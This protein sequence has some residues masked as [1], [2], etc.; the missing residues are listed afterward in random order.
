M[1]S[2]LPS[3]DPMPPD[4]SLPPEAVEGI[5]GSP[6]SMYVHIPF[7]RTRCGYCDFNTYTASELPGMSSGDYVSAAHREIALAASVLGDGAPP[8]DTVFFGGGTP[9]MLPAE[10]LAGMLDAIRDRFGLADDA[11]VTTEANPDTVD[12]AYFDRLRESG[13]TRISLGM[14]SVVPHVLSVLERVH[15]PERGLQ[16]ARWAAEAGFDHVSLDLIYGTPGESADDWMASLEAVAATPVDHVSAY[17]LIVEEG[18]RLAMQVRRG[19]IPMPDDDELAD[20]Y[21]MA[22]QF[23]TGHGFANY[24]VSNWAATPSGQ[25]RHNLN[26]W[27][28]ANWW[29]VGPGAHSH[30]GGLRFWNRKHPRSYVAELDAG[31]SPV[32][33]GEQLSAEDRRI[34]TVMLELRLAEGL[35]LAVLTDSERARVPETV[36]RGLGVIEGQRLI[37]TLQG[38]LLADG[39][40]RN[41]LD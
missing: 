36:E 30:V 7:C 6:L 38:R 24:E 25:C 28:G 9:T 35:D 18:T 5:G 32:Q 10:T 39:V 1:P 3:G 29:G 41:L 17:S 14:Q 16:A 15:T 22:E 21:L 11:E 19:Q 4:G 8:V 34:E 40:V 13:F 33:A 12:R 26:Y 31:R 23:L 2:A 20:K 27:R 37:L